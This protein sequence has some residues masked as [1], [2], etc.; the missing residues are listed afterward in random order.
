MGNNRYVMSKESVALFDKMLNS[1]GWRIM[2][3][4]ERE[5]ATAKW[6]RERPTEHKLFRLGD[7][8]VLALPAASLRFLGW[9]A[10]DAVLVS[11][12]GKR[13]IIE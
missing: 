11:L 6:D 2:S 7:A 5:Q 10:G 9:K 1:P 13:L 8:V 4:S 12:D 3:S